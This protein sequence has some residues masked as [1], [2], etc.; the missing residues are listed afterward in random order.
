MNDSGNRVFVVVALLLAFIGIATL[1]YAIGA[2]N[3]KEWGRQVERCTQ[4][5][6]DMTP[7]W[8]CA[9][10]TVQYVDAGDSQ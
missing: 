9:K 7:D 10:V 5:G 8:R 2:R 1:S 4:A 3:G 6:G